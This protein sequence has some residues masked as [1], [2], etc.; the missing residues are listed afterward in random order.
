VP[1]PSLPTPPGVPGAASA[2]PPQ[3]STASSSPNPRAALAGALAASVAELLAAG[4]THGAQVAVEALRALVDAGADPGQGAVVVD[5]AK[6]R[7]PR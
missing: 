3:G 1:E 4:D 2:D 5:L 6:R 7:G